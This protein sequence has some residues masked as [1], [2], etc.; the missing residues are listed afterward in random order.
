[1]VFITFSK[2]SFVVK[3]CKPIAVLFMFH[4]LLLYLSPVYLNNIQY[5]YAENKHLQMCKMQ[6]ER[7]STVT[8]PKHRSCDVVHTESAAAV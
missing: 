6:H 1:M 4:F 5:L 2:V 3:V 8:S 7:C